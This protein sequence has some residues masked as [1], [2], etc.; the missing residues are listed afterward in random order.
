MLLLII[1]I[2]IKT[3]QQYISGKNNINNDYY[4]Y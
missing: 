3:P 2:T 1:T 4:H